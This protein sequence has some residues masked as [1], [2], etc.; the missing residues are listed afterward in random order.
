M[1]LPQ[2]LWGGSQIGRESGT[3]EGEKWSSSLGSQQFK[4]H[5]SFFLLVS[6][7]SI[8][9]WNLSSPTEECFP[10]FSG[11]LGILDFS[12]SPPPPLRG[13]AMIWPINNAQILLLSAL[14]PPRASHTKF[15]RV[16]W[17][18]GARYQCW[19]FSGILHPRITRV[20]ISFR[21]FIMF[22]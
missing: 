11:E 6:H 14:L 9:M 10:P 19:P 16:L 22:R 15:P 18:Y 1:D 8:C 13:Q 12:G 21:V 5:Q 17:D 2:G 3:L 7:P 20:M 4:R